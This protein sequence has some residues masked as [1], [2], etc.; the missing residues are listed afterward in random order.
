MVKIHECQYLYIV[1]WF[2]RTSEVSIFS[3]KWILF[4]RLR[5]GFVY[6][7]SARRTGS[8]VLSVSQGNIQ[9]ANVSVT[10]FSSWKIKCN[11]NWKLLLNIVRNIY[12]WSYLLLTFKVANIM[13]NNT[14]AIWVQDSPNPAMQV[15]WP[16]FMGAPSA[17]L[18]KRI[19][20]MRFFPLSFIECITFE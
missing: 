10:V 18:S 11:Y 1:P 7:I 5:L 14:D 4:F 20:I 17:S 8:N 15:Q 13:K 6:F 19:H 2:G 12:S 16:N 9:Y 3:W